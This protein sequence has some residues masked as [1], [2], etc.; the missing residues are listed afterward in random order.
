MKLKNVLT[1]PIV[2]TLFTCAFATATVSAADQLEGEFKTEL[3]KGFIKHKMEFSVL[4]EAYSTEIKLTYENGVDTNTTPSTVTRATATCTYTPT[5]TPSI[6][7]TGTGVECE[8]E[9]AGELEM[10]VSYDQ[11]LLF[12]Q[13]L[14]DYFSSL[15]VHQDIN[16]LSILTNQSEHH[17]GVGGYTFPYEMESEWE[18]VAIPAS[19]GGQD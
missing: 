18:R 11:G 12:A 4:P 16:G 8:I 3:K 2:A 15:E 1:V 6:I 5:Q 7:V 10:K 14:T 17:I 9:D 19:G 13:S